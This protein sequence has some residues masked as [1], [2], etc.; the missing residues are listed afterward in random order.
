MP[1]AVYSSYLR[2]ALVTRAWM[3]SSKWAPRCTFCRRVKMN[4]YMSPN[5]RNHM[6][7]HPRV[8]VCVRDGVNLYARGPVTFYLWVKTEHVPE[9][10][11]DKEKEVLSLLCGREKL[12]KMRGRDIEGGRMSQWCL[13]ALLLFS[14]QPAI[15]AGTITRGLQH[16]TCMLTS[17]PS[18]GLIY[19]H[20]KHTEKE[21][22]SCVCHSPGKC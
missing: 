4:E 19:K 8:I 7:T 16:P 1:N 9:G 22:E 14:E 18:W 10:S 15:T 6:Q 3:N 2:T 17:T 11:V 5:V 12:R 21:L 13:L 20:Y